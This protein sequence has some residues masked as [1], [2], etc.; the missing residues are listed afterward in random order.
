MKALD[1]LGDRWPVL[2]WIAAEMQQLH[3]DLR[4]FFFYTGQASD[5]KSVAAAEDGL[6]RAEGV[7]DVAGLF[8]RWNGGDVF[9]EHAERAKKAAADGKQIGVG[10]VGVLPDSDCVWGDFKVCKM[11]TL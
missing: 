1:V 7:I 2:L 8:Y 11:R 4:L 10:Q 6:V 5:L 3:L 9:G